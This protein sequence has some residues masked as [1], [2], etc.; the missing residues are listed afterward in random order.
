MEGEWQLIETAPKDGGPVLLWT[1][2]RGSEDEWYVRDLLDG[3]HFACHQ[4]GCWIGDA[5]GWHVEK[6]GAPTHWMPLPAPPQPDR[7]PS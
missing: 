4:I 3:E 7:S 6:I 5:G 1:D 2:T